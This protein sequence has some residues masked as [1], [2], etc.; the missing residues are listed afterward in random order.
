MAKLNIPGYQIKAHIGSGGMAVVFR[1]TQES[2]QR[3]VALK[4]LK[5]TESKEWTERFLNEGR[6]LAEGDMGELTA[7]EEVIEAY[8]GR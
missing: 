7:N 2:L 5:N 4:V 1:A 3:S 8:L 6:I